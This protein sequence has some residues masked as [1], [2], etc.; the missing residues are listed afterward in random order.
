MTQTGESR[1]EDAGSATRE[2]FDHRVEFDDRTPEDLKPGPARVVDVSGRCADCWGPIAGMKDASGRWNH[3]EC[4][5]CGRSVDEEKAVREVEAMQREA[6]D[7]MAAVR[8][9]QPAIYRANASFVLKLL[10]DM[11]RDEAEVERRIKASLAQGR[12]RGRL[13]RHEI[14]PGTAGYLYGQA[15]GFLAGVENLSGQKDAIAMTDLV[16]G[17][18]QLVGIDDS[19][20][21]GTIHVTG[22]IPAMHRKPSNRELMAR[23]GTALV[24]GMAGSFACEVGMK[25]I[26]VTRLDTAA[27]T[28][29]L[30]ALY[31]ELP[32]DSRDRL[33]G[34]FPEIADVLGHS[35]E[36]FGKWRYFEQGIG[37]DAIRSLVDTDRVWG[38]GKAARVI[39]DEC[40]VAGLNCEI[41][42]D[43]T[44][45]V[46]GRPGDFRAS[47]TVHLMLE[48]GESSI[49]WDEILRREA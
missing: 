25:A 41:D 12:K 36:T 2:N 49:P 38:L 8:V 30:L 6:H 32:D 3:I 47:Q 43:T 46:E 33:E 39:V 42:I 44:F 23:M 24:A 19:A 9:G 48:G 5:L 37:E 22:R 18:P 17:E 13:T 34:D 14:P 45:E 21:D 1:P 29:D 20:G 35:R 7:N 10:P 28:H 26:L 31:G 27:K 4:L 15:R 40:V 11:D 16:Y